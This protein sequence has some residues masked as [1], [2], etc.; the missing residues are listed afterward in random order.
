MRMSEKTAI[1]TKMKILEFAQYAY[2]NG[3]K[4]F[5]KND[6]GLGI[7]VSDIAKALAKDN[8]VYLLTHSG[9][10]RGCI[11]E[12]IHIVNKTWINI[13]FNLKL[14]DLMLAVMLMKK[15]PALKDKLRIL[16]YFAEVG[17]FRKVVKTI[18]P[19]IV[20]IE[21][22]SIETLPFL[23]SAKMEGYPCVVTNHG[24]AA[25]VRD[26]EM[27]YEHNYFEFLNEQNVLLTTVSTGI[28]ERILAEHKCVSSDKIYVVL[29]GF[30][31]LKNDG[32]VNMPYMKNLVKE[33]DTVFLSIGKISARK[34]Q[35]AIVSALTKLN[36]KELDGLKVIFVGNGPEFENLQKQIAQNHLES[37]AFCLGNV[38]H[39]LMNGIYSLGDYVIS[40]SLDEGFGLPF[41]EGFSEG[42]PSIT[43]SDLDA[44]R[45]IYSE[46][47]MLL[48]ESRDVDAFAKAI[49]IAK[50][51]KWDKNKIIQ[52]S[53]KFSIENTAKEYEKIFL[54]EI[55]KK[56]ALKRLDF[57]EF[58]KTCI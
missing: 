32:V 13:F 30:S 43:F 21:N 1:N 36:K 18:N 31:K 46:N 28:K 42:L 4:G 41:I 2:F 34:N 3:V 35:K 29:N 25:Y 20:H 24:L 7:A 19:D 14:K 53:Q 17:Y 10:G 12:R 56:T 54:G 38:D 52:H 37:N 50:N 58:I 9:F 55:N 39:N 45:D 6:T 40:S 15:L 48:V 22:T 23:I 8:E 57:M 26:F 16:A 27:R 11:Y 33:S 47:A 51:L 49:T 5:E 44:I